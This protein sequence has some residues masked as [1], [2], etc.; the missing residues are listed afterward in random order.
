MGYKIKKFS[1]TWCG[2]CKMLEQRLKDY[3]RCEIEKYD[4]DEIDEDVI[5]KYNIRNVPT[6]I[7]V[8]D[9]DNE[10]TRLAGL[11]NTSDLDAKLDELENG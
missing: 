1:A 3:T 11:F 8:D 2:P 4:V 9:N 7:I 5:A 6:V 10:I